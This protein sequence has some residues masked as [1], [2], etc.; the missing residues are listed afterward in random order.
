MMT[1]RAGMSVPPRG[2][3]RG[4]GRAVRM[5]AIRHSHRQNVARRGPTCGCR[6]PRRRGSQRGDPW[7]VA[8]GEWVLLRTDDAAFGEPIYM[9]GRV[10]GRFWASARVGRWTPRWPDLPAAPAPARRRAHRHPGGLE[11]GTRRLPAHARRLLD[12]P[13][14]P[15]QLAQRHHLLLLLVAQDVGHP[16]GGPWPARRRQRPKSST[17][18]AALQPAITGRFARPPRRRCADHRGR[19]PQGR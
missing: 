11:V 18:S 10:A 17:P 8:S 7:D 16:G 4:I 5:Y 12:A 3:A 9:L 19:E 13:Q 15:A 2:P 1:R 6:I 14:G